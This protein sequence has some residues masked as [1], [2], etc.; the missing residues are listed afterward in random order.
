[1]W[2]RRNPRAL[3]QR[4]AA[5]LAA[6]APYGLCLC[7]AACGF[8]PMYGTHAGGSSLQTHL[9]DITVDRIPN[10]VGQQLRNALEQGIDSNEG[11]HHGRYHL[12]VTLKDSTEDIAIRRTDSTTSRSDMRLTASWTLTEGDTVLHRGEA[13]T[14]I[15][16]AVLSNQYPTIASLDNAKQRGA[17]LVAQDILRQ[18]QAYFEKPTPW[19]PSTEPEPPTQSSITLPVIH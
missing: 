19:V 14:I 6:A 17:E 4:A 10:H 18:L 1:M 7:L 16:Y 5:L 11:P 2:W 3:K 12:Q 9:A 15:G 13:E 8:E